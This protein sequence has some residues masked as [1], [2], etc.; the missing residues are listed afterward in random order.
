MARTA[1]FSRK[2]S[3]GV[4]SIEDMARGTGE[5]FFVHS[6]TG[7]NSVGGGQNPDAPLATIDYAVALC[8]ADKGDVIYVMPGHAEVVSA[9]AG[10]DLDVSGITIIGLGSGANTP[11]V[12]FDSA[13]SSGAYI[14]AS[15]TAA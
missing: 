2:Q 7:T 14:T 10:L 1:L 3:G 4:F 15:W 9:A 8:T 5:R 13:P 12:T 11:T 6:G